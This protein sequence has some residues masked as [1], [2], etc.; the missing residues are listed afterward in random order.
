MAKE[1]KKR[2]YERRLSTTECT[3]LA[4]EKEGKGEGE[5]RSQESDD[6]RG[7][8]LYWVSGTPLHTGRRCVGFEGFG[9]G[10]SGTR[11]RR[12]GT[13]AGGECLCQRALGSCIECFWLDAGWGPF[14]IQVL[15]IRSIMT[16]GIRAASNCLDKCG[17]A[18]DKCRP[19][20]CRRGSWGD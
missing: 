12:T 16:A 9:G 3:A 18:V 19:A 15:L 13:G 14:D 10:G 4:R 1:S 8:R 2:R 6:R 20:W 5:G 11:P 7:R 17:A